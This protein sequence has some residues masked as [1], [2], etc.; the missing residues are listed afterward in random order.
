MEINKLVDLN[1]LRTAPKLS[2]I[3]AKKLLKTK[4]IN[5]KSN[6]QKDNLAA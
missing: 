5:L 6:S 4:T 2:K 3:Q 1:S